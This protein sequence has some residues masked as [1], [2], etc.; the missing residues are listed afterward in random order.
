MKQIINSVVKISVQADR[1]EDFLRTFIELHIDFLSKNHDM[2]TFLLWE[3]KKDTDL[4]H[5]VIEKFSTM[6]GTPLEYFTE[7]IKSA[8]NN[9]EIRPIEPTDFALNLASLDIFPFIVLPPIASGMNLSDSQ[10][11]VLIERRK[12]EIFRLLWDDIKIK[13]Q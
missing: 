2:L 8:V 3:A 4:V 13:K 7:K 5:T 10:M 12:E 11:D 9:G 6:G 1:F